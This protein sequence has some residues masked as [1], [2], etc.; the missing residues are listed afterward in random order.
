MNAR[1]KKVPSRRGGKPI[2]DPKAKGTKTAQGKTT[3]K[4]LVAMTGKASAAKAAEGDEPTA[5]RPPQSSRKASRPRAASPAQSLSSDEPG[6][7]DR[8]LAVL[9]STAPRIPSA[10]AEL[11]GV[12]RV[13]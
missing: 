5:V 3:T 7:L 10:W 6:A 9:P 12:A 13:T 1:S 2:A 4:L 8:W 11:R